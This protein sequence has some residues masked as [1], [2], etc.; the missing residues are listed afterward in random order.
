MNH[1]FFL[2]ISEVVSAQQFIFLRWSTLGLT[3]APAS[4]TCENILL[5]KKCLEVRC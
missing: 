4:P 2:E 3:E 5:A 1:F